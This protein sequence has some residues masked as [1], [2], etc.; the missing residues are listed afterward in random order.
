MMIIAMVGGVSVDSTSEYE[1][2]HECK[3]VKQIIMKQDE[4]AKVYCVPVARSKVDQLFD[5][6]MK[7]VRE[8]QQLGE[9]EKVPNEN[10]LSKCREGWGDLERN[11]F[12]DSVKKQCS[13][14]TIQRRFKLKLPDTVPDI[15]G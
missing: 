4:D 13:G 12:D 3:V 14:A 9:E 5:K 10:W 15:R 6:F 2:M 7:L 8:M 1:S 11:F